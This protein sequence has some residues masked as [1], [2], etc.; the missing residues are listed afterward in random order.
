MQFKSLL[1]DIH[2]LVHLLYANDNMYLYLNQKSMYSSC[3]WLNL[4]Y[5]PYSF[6]QAAEKEVRRSQ[7]RRSRDFQV[8]FGTWPERASQVD[9]GRIV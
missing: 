8:Y 5:L 7:A 3:A 4:V 9:Q 1:I 2:T 6:V